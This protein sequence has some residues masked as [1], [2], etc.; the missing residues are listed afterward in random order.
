MDSGNLRAK[1]HDWVQWVRENL[2]LTGE[3]PPVTQIEVTGLWNQEVDDFFFDA[4]KTEFRNELL[5]CFEQVLAPDPADIPA[6]FTALHLYHLLATTSVDFGVE[7]L[8][9]IREHAESAQAGFEHDLGYLVRLL[10]PEACP[11]DWRTVSWEILN[12]YL[13]RDWRRASALYSKAEELGL[14]ERAELQALRGQFKFLVVFAPEIQKSVSK[15]KLKLNLGLD[16]LAW[17]PRIY[18]PGDELG[19]LYSVFL[20]ASG[21]CARASDRKLRDSDRDTLLEAT[22]DLERALTGRPTLPSVY[23]AMLGRCHFC[24][25]HFSEAAKQYELLLKTDIGTALAH[26]K[27]NIYESM[28]VCFQREGDLPKAERTLERC[29]AEFPRKKEIY[30]KLAEVQ[31]QL[32]K[33]DAVPLTVRLALEHAPELDSDWRLSSLLALGEIRDRSDALLAELKSNSPEFISLHAFLDDYWPPFT[34]METEARDK[35]VA[36]TLLLHFSPQHAKILSLCRREAVVFFATAIEQELDSKFFSKFREVVNS[37][38]HLRSLAEGSLEDR[39]FG[40]FCQF[41]VKGRPLTMGAML[42]YIRSC[43]S[44]PYEIL[45]VFCDWLKDKH[46]PMDPT[47]QLLEQ[48]CP[49]RNKAH[50][51]GQSVPNIE[52]L[53]ALCRQA[54][55]LLVPK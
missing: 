28:A 47:I 4:W 35:W 15:L 45:R 16:S 31:A 12:S 54:I 10:P 2:D 5:S 32:S 50:H 21:L 29:V 23:R 46:F 18:G 19:E 53:P 7:E 24:T 52:E 13:V 22:L 1:I 26:L 49:A 3:I 25:G 38:P 14:L 36:G 9:L 44:K 11:P 41:L 37:K 6:R 51:K 20:F 30:L 39:E 33:F 17:G 48:I 27:P 55:E 43:N 8:G 34:R 42:N 40:P